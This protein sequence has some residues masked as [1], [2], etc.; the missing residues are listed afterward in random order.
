MSRPLTN[1]SAADSPSNTLDA[2]SSSTDPRSLN[3]EPF[4]VSTKKSSTTG[5]TRLYAPA[6]LDPGTRTRSNISSTSPGRRLPNTYPTTSSTS[7]S[8]SP[9]ASSSSASADSTPAIPSCI[10]SS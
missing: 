10:A 3:G 8:T 6:T 5:T 1:A 2:P 4:T 7:P 9:R